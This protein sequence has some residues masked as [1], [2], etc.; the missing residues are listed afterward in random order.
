M[1]K[2]DEVLNLTVKTLNPGINLESGDHAIGTKRTVSIYMKDING[3]ICFD[4]AIVFGE[5][6]GVIS[7]LV[8][9]A[10]K[11]IVALET[12]GV[13]FNGA[14]FRISYD[15]L[16]TILCG[17]EIFIRLQRNGGSI[18]GKVNANNPAIQNWQNY[19]NKFLKK[20]AEQQKAAKIRKEEQAKALVAKQEQDKIRE[21]RFYY[22]ECEKCAEQ[23]RAK[24]LLCKECGSEF[25]DG[26]SRRA[27]II[28]WENRAAQFNLKPWD[29]EKIEHEEWKLT[30]E[31][32]AAEEKRIQEE[33]QQRQKEQREQAERLHQERLREIEEEELRQKELQ[34]QGELLI[35]TF[36]LAV[37]WTLTITTFGLGYPLLK[38]AK[39]YKK[40]IEDK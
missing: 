10:G 4:T 27:A 23:V 22:R 2:Y 33:L 11:N 24:A 37:A 32:K 16:N 6:L 36:L 25:E 15:D 18:D 3:N 9:R 5:N 20:L 21:E 34:K 40:Q 39:S 7:K 12:Q 31:G 1:G 8:L 30:P 29:F 19:Y 14:S 38:F 35:A 28:D 26:P 13:S 17:N